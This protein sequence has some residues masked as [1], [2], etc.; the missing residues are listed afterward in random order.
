MKFEGEASVGYHIR[1]HLLYKNEHVAW[2]GY[3]IWGPLLY[4]IE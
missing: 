3:H 4:K 2:T 1:V